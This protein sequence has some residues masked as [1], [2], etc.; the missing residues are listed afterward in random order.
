MFVYAVTVGTGAGSPGSNRAHDIGI[1]ALMTGSAGG[2]IRL[3]IGDLGSMTISTAQTANRGADLMV[4]CRLMFA[5][6]VAA[7][8]GAWRFGSNR[9]NYSWDRAL[10]TGSTG[11]MIC[12]SIGHLGSMTIGTG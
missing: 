5:G 4:R 3:G 7:G 2:M 11:G 12:L 6:A 9:G 10:M 8:A 1:R